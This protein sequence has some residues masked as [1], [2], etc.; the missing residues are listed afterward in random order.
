MTELTINKLERFPNIIEFIWIIHMISNDKMGQNTAKFDNEIENIFKVIC[1]MNVHKGKYFL[2]ATYN[3]TK[4]QTIRGRPFMVS[5]RVITCYKIIPIKNSVCAQDDNFSRIQ[6]IVRKFI[7][8]L[9]RMY[10]L[11]VNLN[12]S[13]KAQNLFICGIILKLPQNRF[14]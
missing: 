2:L 11:L 4:L 9:L 8:N 6:N 3:Q 1:G 13:A 14:E 7:N 12:R 5:S 10:S